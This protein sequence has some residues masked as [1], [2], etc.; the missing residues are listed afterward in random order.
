LST[1]NEPLGEA[2]RSYIKPRTKG[3][4]FLQELGKFGI[5]RDHQQ[6][7]GVI[8][9]QSLY[10]DFFD[11]G[12]HVFLST[13]DTA[14]LVADIKRLLGPVSRVSLDRD[15]EMPFTD[16]AL[17]DTPRQEMDPACWTGNSTLRAR[18]HSDNTVPPSL[19]HDRG[20]GRWK[21]LL[22]RPP[23]VP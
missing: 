16:I 13:S 5:S 14:V 23:S 17:S 2:I 1:V 3:F 21:Q 7:A 12:V 18:K 19:F 6:I 10:D 8:A 22:I 20:P 4:G 9:H 11:K 15:A